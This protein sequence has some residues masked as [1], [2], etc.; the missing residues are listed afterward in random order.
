M[1]ERLPPWTGDMMNPES[2]MQIFVGNFFK[3]L[4]HTHEMKKLKSGFL[5][6]EMLE[7][8][9][10]KAESKLQPDRSLWIYSGHDLTIASFLNSLGLYDVIFF[11]TR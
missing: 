11:H 9:A 1:L 10:Q 6:K 3:F 4:T 8:F 5:I 2:D 7:R